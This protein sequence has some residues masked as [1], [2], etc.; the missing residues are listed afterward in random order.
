M[1][2]VVMVVMVH[3]CELVQFHHDRYF[4]SVIQVLIEG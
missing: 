2:C 1:I 3:G 4:L